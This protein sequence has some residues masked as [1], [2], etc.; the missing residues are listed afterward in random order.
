MAAHYCTNTDANLS[1]LL[2]VTAAKP[3]IKLTLT[4]WS[5][6]EHAEGVFICYNAANTIVAGGPDAYAG[7]FDVTQDGIGAGDKTKSMR[8]AR[9]DAG[10]FTVGETVRIE[11]STVQWDSTYLLAIK[12]ILLELVD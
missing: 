1:K 3:A 4:A 11:L 6:W 7:N 2:E 9:L 12:Q 5:S 10:N 8:F